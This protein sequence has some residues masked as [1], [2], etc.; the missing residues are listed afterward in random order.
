MTR[1]DVVIAAMILLCAF[2][3][4]VIVAMAASNSADELR[5]RKAL[6]I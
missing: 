3:M 5:L 6:H 1:Y 2:V 4:A